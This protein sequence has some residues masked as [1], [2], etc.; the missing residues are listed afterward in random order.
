MFFEPVQFKLLSTQLI[1]KTIAII[2]QWPVSISGFLAVFQ[3]FVQI[4]LASRWEVIHSVEKIQSLYSHTP[5]KD[6]ISVGFRTLHLSK[7]VAHLTD[8]RPQAPVLDSKLLDTLPIALSSR[9]RPKPPAFL[10]NY[11]I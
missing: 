8:L 10:R 3:Q 4:F 5:K 1:F 11:G 6:V 2:F 7:I 9:P